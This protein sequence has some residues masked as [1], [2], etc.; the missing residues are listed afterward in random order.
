MHTTVTL[1]VQHPKLTLMNLWRDIVNFKKG[2]DHTEVLHVKFCSDGVAGDEIEDMSLGYVDGIGR[3]IVMHI[4]MSILSDEV[5]ES[6][7][8]GEGV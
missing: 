4:V 6:T 3:A 5:T 2:F 7:C 1:P 8:W